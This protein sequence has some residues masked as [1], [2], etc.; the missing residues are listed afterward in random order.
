MA[1]KSDGLSSTSGT[2]GEK[3]SSDPN[4]CHGTCGHTLASQTGK[5][6]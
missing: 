6:I 5:C 1:A 4:M 2:K 3:L